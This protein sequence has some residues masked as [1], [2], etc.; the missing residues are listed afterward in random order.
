MKSVKTEK[1]RDIA[2]D[3]LKRV[4]KRL[5][6]SA[7]FQYVCVHISKVAR[8]GEHGVATILRNEIS[9][10]I[11]PCGSVSSWLARERDIPWEDL[12]YGN[13]LLYRKR[14]VKSMITE[15][16]SLTF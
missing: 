13:T 9:R 3:L 11:S 4:D 1:Q 10:R 12:T 2:V 15:L 7:Q 5:V 16:N 8:A 14:W 6:K